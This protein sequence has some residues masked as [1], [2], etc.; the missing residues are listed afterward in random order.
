[1]GFSLSVLPFR[2]LD[3]SYSPSL[4]IA[5]LPLFDARSTKV[6]PLRREREGAEFTA[7]PPGGKPHYGGEC[8]VGEFYIGQLLDPHVRCHTGRDELEYLHRLLAHDMRA[9][10]SMRLPRRDEF[11]EAFPMAIDEGTV[12]CSV[13]HYRYDAVMRGMC[14]HFGEANAAILRIG[15]TAMR[16]DPVLRGA[17]DIKDSIFC[18]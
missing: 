14:L 5:L 15:K 2:S 1:M 11:A 4:R 13:W 18:R 9:H 7:E 10:D 6:L 12:Q 17:I 16:D 3:A 8:G